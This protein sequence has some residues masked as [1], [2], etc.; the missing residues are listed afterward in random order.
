MSGRQLRRGRW[1]KGYT[2]GRP[3]SGLIKSITF[4][5]P[6]LSLPSSLPPSFFFLYPFSASSF[7]SFCPAGLLS[8]SFSTSSLNNCEPA[9]LLFLLPAPPHS[10]KGC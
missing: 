3:P 8:R 7:P 6:L 5:K 2:E 10:T 9:A 1:G 4:R